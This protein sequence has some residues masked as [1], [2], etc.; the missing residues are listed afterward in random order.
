MRPSKTCPFLEI[1]LEFYFVFGKEMRKSLGLV[2]STLPAKYIY[3]HI[4]NICDKRHDDD[5]IP[6]NVE[7]VIE[8]H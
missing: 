5:I 4:Y 2:V 7:T 1:I 3:T 8:Y 6:I